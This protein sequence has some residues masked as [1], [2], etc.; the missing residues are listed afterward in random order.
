MFLVQHLEDKQNYVL[1]K[2]EC[3]DEVD[4]NKAF[5]EAMALNELRHPYICGYKEFFVTWDKE[6]S[7][8]F[9]CIVMDYYPMGDLDRVL[10]QRRKHKQPMEELIIKK[11]LGQMIEALVFVHQKEVI[12]RDL[13]PSNIFLKED[14]SLSL[15]DFGVATIMGDKRT[16]TRTTVGSMNW[17]APEVLERPYD[18]RSDVWSMGCITLEMTTCQILDATQMSGHLFE[19]KNNPQLLEDLL[20]RVGGED[21]AVPTEDSEAAGATGSK[22][23]SIDLCALIR[24]MLRRNFQQRPKAVDLVDYPYVQECLRLNASPL[25]KKVSVEAEGEALVVPTS[26]GVE[27]IHSF[28]IDHRDNETAITMGLKEL[29]HMAKSEEKFAL[30]TDFKRLLLLQMQN[31]SHNNADIP[32]TCCAIFAALLPEDEDALL[33]S[34]EMIKTVT[35]SMRSHVGSQNLQLEACQLLM[36]LSADEGACELI[37]RIGGVQDILGAMRSF[38]LNSEICAA[39]CSALWSLTVNEKNAQIVTEE[40]GISD[41]VTALRNHGAKTDEQGEDLVESVCAAL[42]SLSMEEENIETLRSTNTMGLLVSALELHTSNALVV[43]N[44][45]LAMASLAEAD[46]ESAIKVYKDPGGASVEGSAGAEG[47]VTEGDSDAKGNNLK[48]GVNGKKGIPIIL[49]AYETHKENAEVVESICSLLLELSDYDEL[50]SVLTN[51]Q[52]HK[53]VLKEITTRFAANE[54]V[55]SPALAVLKR[56]QVAD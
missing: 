32:T 35:N 28:L 42:L 17:M 27:G 33:Y 34:A 56:L 50:C 39:C 51:F 11:W 41:V 2:V 3:N 47:G 29:H 25:A 14:L 6:E 44:A 5:K 43:K 20:N 4:A 19:L 31:F 24:T 30:S 8:M 55:M 49:K 13:K 26:R 52:L 15:G 37:G 36:G 48:E 53:T 9:V 7:A 1:K 40:K 12:H 54:E 38:H 16:K 45:C 21:V 18:E 23:Y 46:E 10:K 22:L